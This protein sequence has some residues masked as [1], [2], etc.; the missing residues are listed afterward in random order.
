MFKEII[1][2][3]DVVAISGSVPKG[4]H[5]DI[6]Q[7]MVSMCKDI[8][9]KVLLDTSGEVLKNGIKTLPTLIKPNEDEMAMLLN[10]KIES[11][12]EV[13]TAAKELHEKGIEYVVVSLGKEGALL[14]CDE[15]V[16]HAKPPK[17]E[18]VN[19]VGCDDSKY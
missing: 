5:K 2:D 16:F 4:L 6:Y 12:E 3:S 10:K 14:V 13:V 9:K 17:V 11:I 7:R 18:V 15:G 8:G 1:K 19:T